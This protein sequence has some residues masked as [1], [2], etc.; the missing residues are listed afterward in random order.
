MYRK[1]LNNLK[2]VV[3]NKRVGELA[4]EFGITS[5]QRLCFNENPLGPSPKALEAIRQALDSVNFYPEPNEKTL[6]ALLASKLGIKEGQIIF[7]D[8]GEEIIKMLGTALISEGDEIIVNRPSFY[9]YEMSALIQGGITRKSDLD[10]N[11]NVN[12][13]GVMSLVGPR[14]KMVCLCNPNNPCGTVIP[15]EI[16]ERFARELPEDVLLLV[17]EA[18]YDFA[19]ENPNYDT[20]LKLLGKR[21]NIAFLRTFSKACGLAGLRLGYLVGNEEL[22]EQLFKV[23]YIFNV[24][25]LAQVAGAAAIEDEDFIHKTVAM[26]YESLAKFCELFDEKG[27][28]YIKPNTN[29]VWVDIKKDVLPVCDEIIKKGYI[30]ANGLP[31]GFN[32]HLRISAG[33]PEQTDDLIAILRNLI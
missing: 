31:W 29:F 27:L 8:G 19:K 11:F 15:F 14:T 6:T 25:K 22:I 13:D 3:P 32:T 16:I 26:S 18:Y 10:E 20:A 21:K 9:A 24:N 30:V 23:K 28:K 12:Y 33:T 7:A 1:E 17:D 5:F 4:K 2:K